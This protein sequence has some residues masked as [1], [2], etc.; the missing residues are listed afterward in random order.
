[1]S[2]FII[3]VAVNLLRSFKEGEEMAEG[4]RLRLAFIGC[5]GHSTTSLQPAL[6]QVPEVEYVAACDLVEERARE[7][8]RRFGARAWYTDFV[9]MLE[10][11]GLDAVVVV[12]HPKMHEEI[13]VECLRRG[14]HVLMEKPPSLTV[15]G[16]RR[17]AE[18][19]R[20]SGKFCMV[21]THWRHMP[22]HALLKELTEREGFGRLTAVEATYSALDRGP[23]FGVED[24]AWGFMLNQAIHPVDCLQF[25]GGRIVE[26]E[27]RGE[28][29]EGE[30]LLFVAHLLFEGGAEGVLVLHG[31]SPAI[32]A[33]V[34]AR[35]TGPAWVEVD[36]FQRL[37]YIGPKPWAGRGGGFFDLSAQTW[38]VGNWHPRTT[39]L[40]YVEEFRHF[41][42]CVLEGEQP[43]A[44]AED[45]YW[46]M[47]VLDATVKSAREKRAVKLT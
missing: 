43:R 41:A 28:A 12:G 4:R 36:N 42:R 34:G 45:A 31:C 13:G 37:R 17:V 20:E 35:G 24:F 22:S 6:C 21:A 40:G 26:V 9:E 25:L 14:F 2:K 7:A 47:R 27:A 30:R 5:G 23:A 44:S 33:R 18:T 29:V 32:Y 8:A 11:E 16:A 15:E 38:E 39:C 1:M 19:A 3:H 46:A 10:K